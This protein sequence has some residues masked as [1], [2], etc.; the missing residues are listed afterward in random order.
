M[1][2]EP[3]ER[4]LAIRRAA[5]KFVSNHGPTIA[6]LGGC[7]ESQHHVAA[8]LFKALKDEGLAIVWTKTGGYE[9]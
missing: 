7:E 2:N 3:T 9:K 5:L 4:V 6:A 1:K 8:K